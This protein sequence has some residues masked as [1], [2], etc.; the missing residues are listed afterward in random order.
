MAVPEKP[1][2]TL[3]EIAECWSVKISDL[4]CWAVGGQLTLAIIAR[5]LC[6]AFCGK[7]S[8]AKSEPLNGV[9]AVDGLEVWPAFNGEIVTLTMIRPQNS[10]PR[11]ISEES[12]PRIAL[13]NL[14][15]SQDEKRRFE[16]E[17][18]LASAPPKT[19]VAASRRGREP[20]HDWEGAMIVAGVY[21]YDNGI[22]TVKEHLVEAVWDWFSK[23]TA[24]IP[25]IRTVRRKLEKF[26][27]GYRIA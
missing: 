23:T 20:I 8:S 22:P 18:E 24:E 26:F 3:D 27:R 7:R 15:V 5:N 4:G 10:A 1:F 13:S 16:A 9:I 19:T 14:Y 2:Y 12:R 21:V 25:D 17:S 11:M 6:L